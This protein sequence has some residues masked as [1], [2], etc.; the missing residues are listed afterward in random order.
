MT[1]ERVVAEDAS[2][3]SIQRAEAEQVACGGIAIR[4]FALFVTEEGKI[5]LCDELTR[6]EQGAAEDR[7]LASR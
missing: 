3:F 2:V 1:L 6:L 4:V 7:D 5:V